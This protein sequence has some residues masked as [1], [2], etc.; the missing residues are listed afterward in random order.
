LR[1]SDGEIIMGGPSEKSCLA[2]FAVP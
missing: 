1:A 2:S